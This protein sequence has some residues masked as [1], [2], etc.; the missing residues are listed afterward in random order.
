LAGPDAVP[1]DQ[2]RP[3]LVFSGIVAGIALCT[4]IFFQPKYRRM[5]YEKKH[6]AGDTVSFYS[7]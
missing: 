4:T 5:D 6:T 7:C 3:M 1:Y 2:T